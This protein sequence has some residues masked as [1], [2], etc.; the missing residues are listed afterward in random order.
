M[1]ISFDREA[2]ALYIR[3]DETAIDST[4]EAREGVHLDLDAK[5]RVVGI[6]VLAVTRNLP[7]ADLTKIDFQAA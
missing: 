7:G 5:G 2:D 1:K 4:V 6:E 3:L